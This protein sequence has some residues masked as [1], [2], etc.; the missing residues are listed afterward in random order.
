MTSEQKI[1]FQVIAVRADG[2]HVEKTYPKVN[3]AIRALW[4]LRNIKE[5]FVYVVTDGHR[6]K[7]LTK[8]GRRRGILQFLKLQVPK[9]LPKLK[10]S[11]GNWIR[12]PNRFNELA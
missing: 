6:S 8:V 9:S 7:L 3:H 2:D 5:G 11:P 4:R 10:L 12:L 1:E